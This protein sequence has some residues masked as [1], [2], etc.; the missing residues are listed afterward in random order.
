M[1]SRPDSIR[2]TNVS[3]EARSSRPNNN[4]NNSSSQGNPAVGNEDEVEHEYLSGVKL[5]LV[6][7]AVIA[8]ALLVMLDMSIIATAIPKITSDFHSTAGVGWYGSA[9]LLTSCTLQP[10][11]GKVYSRFN[12]KYTYIAFIALFELGSLVCGVSTSSNMF[13]VGRAIAGMGS[14]GVSNARTL[15]SDLRSGGQIGVVA[16]P[17]IGGALTEYATWRWCFYI[18]LPIGGLAVLFL[19]SISLPEHGLSR[20]EQRSEIKFAS[21]F[22]DLD[23]IGFL[24]LSPTLVMFLLALEWGGTTYPWNTAMVID[25]FC[26]SAGNLVLFLTWE[27]KKGDAAMIPLKMIKQRVVCSSSLTM[28]FLYANSLICSYYLAVYFQ[29]V[30]GE[31]PM[32]SG[33]YMLPGVIAQMISGFLSG[34]AVTRLGYYLPSAVTGTLLTAIGSGLMSLVTPHTSMGK[35]MDWPLIAVQTNLPP[36]KI[37]VSMAFLYFCQN[38][39]G[40]LWLSFASTVFNT[41]LANLLPIYAPNVSVSEVTSAGVSGMRSVIPHSSLVGVGIAYNDAIQHVF[42]M[43]AGTA[44]AAFI[45]SWG[46]GWKSV[47]KRRA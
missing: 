25:L 39:G 14:S 19:L 40:A 12:V 36:S 29:G 47:Q 7:I 21:L 16:S 17:L 15:R 20:P 46:L 43:V 33:V 37:A 41:G 32:F 8:I 34:L 24:L 4:N 6:I 18:N 2:E 10:M 45:F 26:G 9:Y 22:S 35:W 31:P 38:F 13:I 30:R 44:G 5:A 3:R 11:S 1:N 42:Y 27:Y 28:F 23:I